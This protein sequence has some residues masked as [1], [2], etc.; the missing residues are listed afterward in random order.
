MLAK[1]RIAPLDC[2]K[3]GV[4]VVGTR[5]GTKLGASDGSWLGCSEG[6]CVGPSEGM[7]EGLP[8]GSAAHAELKTM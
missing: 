1:P 3:V 2:W 5:V 8:E 4:V 7:S 6:V